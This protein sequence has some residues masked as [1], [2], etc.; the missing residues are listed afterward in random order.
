MLHF[1][2]EKAAV[3]NHSLHFSY[4]IGAL[5][6]P[7]IVRP[8]LSV[9]GP[10]LDQAMANVSEAMFGGYLN[11]T[12]E[13]RS[14]GVY[15]RSDG[16]P[17]YDAPI[18]Y[19]YAIMCVITVACG[20]ALI[21][22]GFFRP[23]RKWCVEEK[24][25]FGEILRSFS[26]TSC[27]HGQGML[28]VAIILLLYL[29]FALPIGA[30]RA[31]GKFVF[32]FAVETESMSRQ[33]GTTLESVFWLAFTAGRGLATLVSG[34]I[35]P[36]TLVLGELAINTVSAAVLSFFVL[37]SPLVLWIFTALF[38]MSLSPLFPGALAW[39]NV[40]IN[41]TAM[42]TGVAFIA[43]AGGAFAFSWLSG[44]LFQ[45]HGEMSLMYLM[46][47]YTVTAVMLFL[48]LLLLKRFY[49]RSDTQPRSLD[50]KDQDVS[51]P[52]RSDDMENDA[53][54]TEAMA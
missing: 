11:V 35:R 36:A 30:E 54:K 18:E 24:V 17:L 27:L 23:V 33:S 39:A 10:I 25:P 37:R 29:F 46:L 2:G 26:P 3:P 44:Y 14:L 8:F 42:A 5:L 48:V 4:G 32:A 6:A 51:V 52:L 20:L 21:L 19:P 22:Y 47:G 45:Y 41:M 7:Q 13:N 31:Y 50:V 28:A 53:K 15:N 16:E 49:D 1:W 40:S 9:P 12:A 34:W 38:A 43:T